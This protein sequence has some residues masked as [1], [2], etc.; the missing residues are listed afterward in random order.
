ML[1][2]AM[3]SLFWVIKSHQKGHEQGSDYRL[4]Y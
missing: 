4:L 2:R 3:I 1:A